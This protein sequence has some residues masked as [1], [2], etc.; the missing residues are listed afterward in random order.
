MSADTFEISDRSLE[1]SAAMV[2]WDTESFGV[3]V[4]RIDRLHVH[5][6]DAAKLAQARLHAW[7]AARQVGLASCRLPDDRLAESLWLEDAGFRFVEMVYGLAV[8]LPPPVEDP[9]T[10]AGPPWAP[11]QRDDLGALQAIAAT[12]FRTG[13][14]QVDPRLDPAWSGRRY[15]DWVRRS[16]DD[17]AHEVLVARIDETV[18]G[19]FIVEQTDARSC[20]WH[21]TAV[22]PGLQGQGL[23]RILWQAMMQRHAAAGIA[24]VR[25]TIAARNIAVVNLYAS[26]GW[27]FVSCE[28][29]FHWVPERRPSATGGVR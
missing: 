16:L 3:P 10:T 28:A 12:A 6:D 7:L 2:P 4:A 14:L 26:L 27:R 11:A 13:R 24:R 19:F 23:G 5:A 20:Y 18:A 29:T 22:A 15:A 17:P 1:L 9:V 21:L 8:D 25:T